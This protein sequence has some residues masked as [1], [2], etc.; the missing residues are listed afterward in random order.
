[1]IEIRNAVENDLPI[2]LEIYN[3]IIVNTTA[4]W[5]HQ[6]HSLEMRQKWF[7]DKKDLGHPVFVAIENGVIVGFS[8]FGVFR[9][10]S[11]YRFTAENSVYVKSDCRGRGIGKLL[12]PPVITAAK[13]FGLHALVAGID[14][15][16]ESSI[17]LHQ[18]FGFEKVAH[19]KQVGFKFDR[20]LDLVFMELIVT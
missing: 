1:M 17:A 4:V 14:A 18:K 13:E 11:G 19:F 3:D 16:N 2:M 10:W 7:A 20:W 12:M 5:D 8:T 6:P 15:D 9:T